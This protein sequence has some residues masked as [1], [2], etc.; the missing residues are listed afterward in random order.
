MNERQRRFADFYIETLNA[1]ES[2]IRA[3]YSK[4]SAMQIGEQN[5]RKFEIKDY[6]AE[7]MNKKESE[8]I[9]KQDEVLMFLTS[10]MRG[11]VTESIPVGVGPGVQELVSNE[12]AAR[13][14]IKAAELL[15]KRYSLF[16]DKLLVD[17]EMAVTLIDDIGDGVDDDS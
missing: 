13:D 7:A 9:A 1:T 5:L 12:P 15:G 16:T 2:A 3:G 4:R 8:R 17:G 11:E 10:V 6:I 14:R